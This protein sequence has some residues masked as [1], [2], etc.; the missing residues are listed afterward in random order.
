MQFKHVHAALERQLHREQKMLN[1]HGVRNLL[2]AVSA[3]VSL[4]KQQL[5]AKVRGLDIEV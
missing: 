5:G 2:Y 1:L 4:S 3:I